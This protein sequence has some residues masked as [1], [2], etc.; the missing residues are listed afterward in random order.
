[1]IFTSSFPCQL[2]YFVAIELRLNANPL[3]ATSLFPSTVNINI[4]YPL[5][6]FLS[7]SL[8]GTGSSCSGGSSS[9][10]ANPDRQFV[11]TT[12]KID[13]AAQS[14][15][16]ILSDISADTATLASGPYFVSQSTG[17]VY[18]AYRLYS[19]FAGAF[20]EGLMKMPDGNYT[21]LSANPRNCIPHRGSIFPTVSYPYQGNASCG[22]PPGSEGRLRY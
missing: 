14:K 8:R 13:I 11:Y 21:Y 18:Q 5:K 2:R 16:S 1:M 12:S 3:E 20:T 15:S 7:H 19:D 17:M 4:T 22:S 9:Y 10:E 6:T